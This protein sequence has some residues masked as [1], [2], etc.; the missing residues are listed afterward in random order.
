M[1]ITLC[2]GLCTRI[3][4]FWGFEKVFRISQTLSSR[5]DVES[6]GV[7]LSVVKRI[8]EMHGG[9]IWVKSKVGQGSTFFF[10]LPK[11]EMGLKDEKLQASIVS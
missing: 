4:C 5:D 3:I 11:Q 6:T 7:G 9:R 8:I 10:T 1:P 2:S